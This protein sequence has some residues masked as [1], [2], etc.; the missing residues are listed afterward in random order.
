MTELKTTLSER[1]N[2]HGDFACNCNVTNKLMEILMDASD[3]PMTRVHQEA[4]HMIC[5]KL[6]R[7]VCG[8]MWHSDNPHDIAGYATL[9]EKWTQ[10]GSANG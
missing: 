4:L 7:I 5:H 2:T 9:L 6:G 1:K 8:D 3:K 10:R